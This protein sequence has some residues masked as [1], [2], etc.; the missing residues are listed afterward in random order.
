MSKSN[1]MRVMSAWLFLALAVGLL[2]N[3]YPAQASPE[4]LPEQLGA[5]TELVIYAGAPA[6]TAIYNPPPAAA[7]ESVQGATFNVAFLPSSG[8]WPAAARTAFQYALTIWGGLINSTV[9]ISITAT[10]ENMGNPNIL[11]GARAAD[12]WAN[13]T[14]ASVTNTWYPNALANKLHNSDL[15]TATPDIEATFNSGF[16]EWYFGTDGLPGTK[17]DF[18][19]VVLHEVGHGLGFAGSMVVG[20]ICGGGNGCWGLGSSYP[21]AY[22]RFAYNGSGQSLITAF[23]NYSSALAAQLTG[24]NVYFTGPF[25][26]AANGNANV[27]L[28]APSTW[29]QGSSYSHLDEIFNGTPNALMTYSLGPNEANHNPGPIGIGVLKDMGWT[30]GPPV[31]L[32]KKLYLPLTSL[33]YSSITPAVQ[34]IYGH[35]NLNGSPVTG[36][37]LELRSNAAGSFTT[38]MTTTTKTG[39]LYNFLGVPALPALKEYY[40]R[41]QNTQFTAGRLW[42]WRT[43]SITSYTLGSDVLI[44]DFDIGD[45]SL[46]TPADG[47][48]ISIP[49]T[50]NWTRRT[51]TTTDSYELEIY[52]PG[53]TIR[54]YSN[55]LGYVNSYVLSSMPA[56]LSAEPFIYWEVWVYPPDYLPAD[57]GPYGV[58]LDTHT[59][60]FSA[61]GL[62]PGRALS[63]QELLQLRLEQAEGRFKDY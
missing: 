34:G 62:A 20:G 63:P 10:W 21:F 43:K 19:S 12:S 31:V 18:V 22:D 14:G 17:I 36:V 9:P 28:F 38:I 26:K 58:S 33:N 47:A 8:A 32:N 29:M 35:V 59:I 6:E 7:A 25:A 45:I 54:W 53:Y 3:G 37:I 50:F 46:G 41:F 52:T 2:G 27:K 15:D 11:G 55:S 23:S 51:A 30:S 4:A 48:S 60:T 49:A 1:K 5:G 56:G 42:F 44:G 16:T 61:L 40:V 57:R 24:G 39:G 13:F